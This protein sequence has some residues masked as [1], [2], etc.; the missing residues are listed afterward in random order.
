MTYLAWGT[1]DGMKSTAD[2]SPQRCAHCGR[3]IY[4][5]A[6]DESWAEGWCHVKSNLRHCDYTH[7][8]AAP[9]DP[10]GEHSF[11]I[12]HGPLDP[13]TRAMVAAATGGQRR[14]TEVHAR[15]ECESSSG[16][17][18]EFATSTVRLGS[19]PTIPAASFSMATDPPAP[20]YKFEAGSIKAHGTLTGTFDSDVLAGLLGFSVSPRYGMTCV[21]PEDADKRCPVCQKPAW[22]VAVEDVRIASSGPAWNPDG[23]VSYGLA[24][25][26][27]SGYRCEPCGHRFDRDGKEI[28][29]A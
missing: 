8:L 23:S 4:Y 20:A 11:A 14:A 24:G 6:G 19:G 29:G 16:D 9:T 17:P 18:F 3:K 27:E 5:C 25:F 22:A 7:N 28:A 12:E 21:F 15:L 10:D 13:S 26:D 1:L 2:Q